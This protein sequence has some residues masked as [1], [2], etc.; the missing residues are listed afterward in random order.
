[1]YQHIAVQK[2]EDIVSKHRSSITDAIIEKS[3][4][5]IPKV[6]IEAELNQMFGQMN[7]DLTRAQLTMESYLEHIKKTE[8]ELRSEW[9]PLAEKRAKLQLVL[10]EIAKKE[11][12]TPD[13]EKLDH[14]VKHLLEHYKDADESR[15][16]TYVSSVLTN[17][18]VLRMLEGV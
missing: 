6:L 1:M 3:T 15:V 16:R 17:E 18:A 11:N 9:G 4:V 2:K 8:E 10:N 14:E 12:V 7:E 13:S 5:E